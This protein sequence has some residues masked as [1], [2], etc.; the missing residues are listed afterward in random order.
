MP[1]PQL[2]VDSISILDRLDF[3]SIKR[4]RSSLKGYLDSKEI[5]ADTLFGIILSRF[6]VSPPP[7]I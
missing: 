2:N 4:K 5:Y 6:P 7:V 1:M 3:D